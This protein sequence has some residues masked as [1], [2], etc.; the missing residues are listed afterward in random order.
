MPRD[1]RMGARNGRLKPGEMRRRAHLRSRAAKPKA[2]AATTSIRLSGVDRLAVNLD[3]VRC[4]RRALVSPP[5]GRDA[6]PARSIYRG[7][8]R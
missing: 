6:L 4:A 8:V 2:V 3:Q 1:G 7:S 5:F